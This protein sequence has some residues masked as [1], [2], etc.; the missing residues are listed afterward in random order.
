[1]AR[2]VVVYELLSLDGVAENPDAYITEF[3]A[4]MEEYLGRVIATQDAVLLGRRTYDAYRLRSGPA[5][6]TLP[7]V[8]QLSGGPSCQSFRRSRTLR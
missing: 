5:S 3:D 6:C 7:S 1:V 4:V 2:R 8:I